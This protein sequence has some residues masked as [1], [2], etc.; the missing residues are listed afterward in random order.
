MD[1]MAK[2]GLDYTALTIAIIGAI[3]WGLIGLFR[4]DII[5][6]IF[7]EMTVL[8]RLIYAAVGLCGLYL[9]S[10]YFRHRQ[11]GSMDG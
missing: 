6:Y 8:T 10:M 11:S 3:S 7:G 2:S 1:M 9:I 5:T 4:F